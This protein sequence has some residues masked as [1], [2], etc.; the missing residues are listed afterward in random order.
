[1]RADW[2]CVNT[3]EAELSSLRSA[4]SKKLFDFTDS[5]TQ[6]RAADIMKR[7]QAI[8]DRT[9]LLQKE[10]EDSQVAVKKANDDIAIL[11]IER[12]DLIGKIDHLNDNIEKL[13]K[14]LDHE[15]ELR[16]NFAITLEGKVSEIESLQLEIDSL[17]SQVN[18]L[19]TKLSQADETTKQLREQLQNAG[20]EPT[21]AGD[22]TQILHLR[23]N[24][25]QCAVDEMDVAERE[26]LRK[27]KADETFAGESSEAKRAREEQILAL[28][29]QLKKSEREKEQALRLQADFAK[30]Y[31]EIATTLTGYQIKLKDIEEGICCVNSVYDDMEKQFVFKYNAETG[32]VDLL[33][34]G[35]D[36]LSQGRP[37]EHEMQKYI[38]ERHSI[39]GFLAAVTLQLEARR[40]LDEVERTD[41]FSILHEK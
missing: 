34:V 41:V 5:S 26:R 20:R 30:K 40:N 9:D 16:S 19:E 23:N 35:Q 3:E 14:S 13:E 33:D 24:P 39:P 1:M 32:I 36:V 8:N 10:L 29:N 11:T 17:R 28:E 18:T 4:C 25:F 15:R 21:D 6:T 7:M 2:F 31:R 22:E 12:D 27:R 38:G 37:W